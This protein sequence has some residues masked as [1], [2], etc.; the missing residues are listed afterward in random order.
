M[1]RL[2]SREAT[3]VGFNPFDPDKTSFFASL[4]LFARDLLSSEDQLLVVG[5]PLLMAIVEHENDDEGD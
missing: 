5:F 4:A 1:S 3:G 2:F